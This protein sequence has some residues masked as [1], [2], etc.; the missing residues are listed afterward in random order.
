MDGHG[1][2][3]EGGYPGGGQVL[4]RRKRAGAFEVS[5][6]E[7]QKE[8]RCDQQ[9]EGCECER[10]PRNRSHD[11]ESNQMGDSA[12]EAAGWARNPQEA[13]RKAQVQGAE[14]R[15]RLNGREK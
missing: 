14:T 1:D 2:R 12:C 5:V 3:G 13:A 6:I 10:V 8:G 15:I 4:R 11:I 9:G 7:E